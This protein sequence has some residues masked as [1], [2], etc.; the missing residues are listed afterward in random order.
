[1]NNMRNCEFAENIF[2][3]DDQVVILNKI[4]LGDWLNGDGNIGHEIIDFLLTDFNEHYIYNNPW[5]HC[6]NNIRV[7]GTKS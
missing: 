3:E 6:P 1:M 5:G 7:N 4:F 2:N